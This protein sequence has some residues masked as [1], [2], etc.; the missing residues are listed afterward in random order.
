MN[1]HSIPT[2]IPCLDQRGQVKLPLS[3]KTPG[4]QTVKCCI[5]VSKQDA[6]DLGERLIKLG[7]DA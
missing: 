7:R 3:W 5:T 1:E 6:V 4:G 2:I